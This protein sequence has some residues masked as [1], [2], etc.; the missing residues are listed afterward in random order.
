[1]LR[2]SREIKKGG[3]MNLDYLA[4]LVLSVA[5]ALT[6]VPFV[7]LGFDVTNSNSYKEDW[8]LGAL[9]HLFLITLLVIFWL[10]SWAID[11]VF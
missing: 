5:Y 7:G 10:M 3:F 11:R 2:P 6:I 8:K 4:Y 9:I 1:M